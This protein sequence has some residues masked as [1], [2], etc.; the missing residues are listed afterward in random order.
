GG[1]RVSGVSVYPSGCVL[2]ASAL[3]ALVLSEPGADSVKASIGDSTISTVNWSEV[4]RRSLAHGIGFEGLQAELAEVGMEV[5]PVTTE[6]AEHAAELWP[7]TRQK[8]LSL[9]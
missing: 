1:C 6:D 5:A 8:G 2:D 4:C 3:L 9:A 7:D